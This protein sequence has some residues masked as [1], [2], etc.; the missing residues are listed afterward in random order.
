MEYTFFFGYFKMH[1]LFP[2]F[3][4]FSFFSQIEPFL[5]L[6]FLLFIFLANKQMWP[7]H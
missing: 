5:V 1:F 6:L 7:L 3:N 4:S 2:F